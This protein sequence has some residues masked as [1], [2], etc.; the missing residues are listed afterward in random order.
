MQNF[1]KN[2]HACEAAAV[3]DWGKMEPMGANQQQGPL[4]EIS[5]NVCNDCTPLS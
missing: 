2:M 4:L 3:K 1:K 5:Y